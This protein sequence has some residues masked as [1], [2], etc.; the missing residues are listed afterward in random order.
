MVWTV[1]FSKIAAAQFS[2]LDKPVQNRIKSFITQLSTLGNPR[3][4]GKFMQGQYTAYYRYR[5]GDY[6]LIC[7][8]DDGKLLVTVIKLGHRQDVYKK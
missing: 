4:N 1:E 8:I 3:H 2:R 7:H 6:R 5:V